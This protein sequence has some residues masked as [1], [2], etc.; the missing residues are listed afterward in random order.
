MVPR[1]TIVYTTATTAVPC[2]EPAGTGIGAVCALS[3]VDKRERKR[4]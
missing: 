2:T 3:A 1:I 4:C